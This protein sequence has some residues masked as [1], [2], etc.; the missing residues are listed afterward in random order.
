MKRAED[1]GQTDNGSPL[2]EYEKED[3]YYEWFREDILKLIPDSVSSV[4]SV[5]CAG[6]ITES[7]LVEKGVKVV[8]LE[9]C[10]YAAER[11]RARGLEVVEGD[12]L[13]A[14]PAL[15]GQQF[16]FLLYADVLEHLQEPESVLCEHCALLSEQGGAVISVPNF[17]HYSVLWAIFVTGEFQYTSAGIFDYTHLRITTRKSV[18]RWLS[19]AELRAQSVVYKIDRRS[20][21]LFSKLTFGLLDEYL[22]TQVLVSA[23]RIQ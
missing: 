4:L 11:A 18:L 10:P 14:M 20:H 23:K 2:E 16:D 1:A 7:A 9:M 17:R 12:L 13:K 5:G 3:T 6:G 8:G 21:R 22:A 15:N 19:Q